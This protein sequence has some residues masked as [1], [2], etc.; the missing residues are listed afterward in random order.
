MSNW[1]S[2]TNRNG[3]EYGG[4]SHD[5][6]W[7]INH[8]GC[9]TPALCLANCTCYAYGRILEAGDLPPVWVIRNANQW[10]NYLTNGWTSIPFNPS[11][12]EPGDL[13]IWTEPNNHV[14][15]VEYIDNGVVHYS[16]SSYT[17]RNTNWSLQQISNY[18]IANYPSRFFSM[19]NTSNWRPNLILKN[20]AHHSGGGP[21]PGPE[22]PGP[23]PDLDLWVLTMFLN[24]KKKVKGGMRYV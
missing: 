1:T 2:R 22:P 17:G 4:W 9:A 14:A 12:C 19:N 21:G 18:M 11:D 13:L 23:E 10:Q 3:L 20:P 8:N 24:K 15:V 7:N 5:N 16:Q 6:F